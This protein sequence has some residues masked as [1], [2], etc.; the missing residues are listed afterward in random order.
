MATQAPREFLHISSA[1]R[2]RRVLVHHKRHRL[3]C[4]HRLI[5]LRTQRDG[6]AIPP[7]LANALTGFPAGSQRETHDTTPI[8]IKPS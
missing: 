8:Q 2:Q 6:D 7:A 1:L 4:G 5:L 3:R